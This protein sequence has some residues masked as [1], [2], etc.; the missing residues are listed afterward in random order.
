MA[1]PTATAFVDEFHKRR[2][3]NLQKE[4]IKH[5]LK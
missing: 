4:E 3:L 5:F 2:R 1:T